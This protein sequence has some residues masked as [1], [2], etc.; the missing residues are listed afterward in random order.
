[1]KEL[2]ELSMKELMELSMKE[3]MG[4]SMMVWMQEHSL[5]IDMELEQQMVDKRTKDLMGIVLV[6][7]VKDS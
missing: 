1:M 3:L 6:V 5:L 2:L 4:L 7:L